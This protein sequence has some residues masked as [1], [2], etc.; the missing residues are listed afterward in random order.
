[1]FFLYIWGFAHLTLNNFW[2]RMKSY[3]NPRKKIKC[4]QE[5]H[6]GMNFYQTLGL[7]QATN[8]AIVWKFIQEFIG[9]Y[10]NPKSHTFFILA[11]L[12]VL[13]LFLF[14]FFSHSLLP[15]STVLSFWRPNFVLNPILSSGHVWPLHF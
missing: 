1:M 13:F 6:V 14:F 5:T 2:V 8:H 11:S 9:P 7:G 4:Q 10:K 12:L 3:Q 15:L